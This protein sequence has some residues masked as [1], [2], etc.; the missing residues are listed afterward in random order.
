MSPDRLDCGLIAFLA[1]LAIA[2]GV[3]YIEDWW[4]ACIKRNITN[5]K[6]KS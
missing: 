1:L 4:D 5:Q 6:E 2:I 3:S